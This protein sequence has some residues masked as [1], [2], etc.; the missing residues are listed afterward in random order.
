MII[1]GSEALASGLVTPYELRMN[2]RRVLPDV[3]APRSLELTLL[4]RIRAAVLWSGR[5]AVV[6]GVAAAALHG[7]RWVDAATVIGLNHANNRAPDGVKTRNETLLHDEVTRIRGIPVTT[8]ERTAF[9][10]ARHGAVVPGVQRL[11]ALARATGFRVQDVLALAAGHPGTPGLL[12]VPQVLDLV[13]AG[14]QSP[15]E[16]YW[17]M[18]FLAAGFPRP[19]TQIPVLG[20]DGSSYFLDMG[21][22]DLMIAAE[23]DG[24]QHRVDRGQYVSDVRRS[25]FIARRWHRVRILGGDRADGVFRRLEAVGLRRTCRPPAVLLQKTGVWTEKVH[26]KSAV[27]GR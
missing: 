25:E 4:D 24:E 6:T 5:Q 18:R 23:Y 17:R 9:D 10:L 1:L 27:K 22:P 7:A 21:W 11:D 8:V 19:Q 26:K 16:T 13:D 12:R 2:F 15:Q 20:P 14:A 3:H